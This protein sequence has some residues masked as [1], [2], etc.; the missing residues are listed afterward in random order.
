MMLKW[1][2][3]REATEVG[4]A[5]A[6]GFV[7]ESAP[8]TASSRRKGRDAD[9]QADL[10]KFLQKFLQRVDRE[11][12]P[13]N[14]NLFKRAKLANS[15]KWRLLEKGIEAPLVDELTQA[16]VLRLTRS[17]P[18]APAQSGPAPKPAKLSARNSQGL[19]QRGAQLLQQGA[20]TE[21]L[22]CYQ[23][24]LGA[25]PRDAFAHNG[26]GSVLTHLMR[27]PEAEEHLRRAI[28]IR[29]SF[30]EAQFN[31][32]CLLQSRG[33]YAESEQPL[34]RS[35]KLKPDR[36]DAR[37][38]LGGSLLLLGRISEARDCYEKALR[39]APRSTVAIVGLAQIE[40]MEGRFAEAEASFRR[41]LE[42]DPHAP[43][44]LVG[45]AR[46][47]RMTAADSE[48]FRRAEDLAAS[49]R[50]PADEATLRFALGKY[51]D[52]TGDHARA[53]R[54]YQRANELH[55]LSAVP[56]D[57]AARAAFVDDMIRVYTREVLSGA[58]A[59]ASNSERPVFVVGM[60]RSGTS[61]VEQIVASHPL[62]HGAGELDFW[63][64]AVHKRDGSAIRR[65]LP[66]ESTRG[67]LAQEYLRLLSTHSTD[68]QRVVDKAPVNSD[69]LGLLHLVFPRARMIYL[70]RDPIDVCLSCY[71]QQFS[72]AMNF[73]MSLP[74]LAQYYREHHR[75]MEYWRAVLPPGVL[76]EVPYA[77]LVADQEQ[78][79]RR[80][81]Q[82]LALPW[83]DRCLEFHKTTRA[84]ATASTWQVRQKIYGSSVQRWRKYEKFVKPLMSLADLQP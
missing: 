52:D 2:D 82:F 17:A 28:G 45:L 73:T 44:A 60:P 68:A 8:A 58:G 43:Y 1:L 41:A 55:K 4:T 67:R 9:G 20:Y 72:P 27:L 75:L 51:Y 24:L 79:T 35:L 21:A 78:W 32:G 54:A 39:V 63:T 71:F 23:E 16:L 30:P 53:F 84:V 13:L 64:A 42:I 49:E 40:A 6:D 26:L 70:R 76:L 10:Q 11:A 50:P 37:L 5:L 3:A 15:F 77:E 36:L 14:L 38:A 56:Y 57:P 83:D 18:A 25:N 29:E 74:D 31:L 81:L 66:E 65:A 69:Y 19:H 59:T 47:R 34:R 61:L 46:M 48:V 62:V 22:E 33:R 80:I 7:L 12:R